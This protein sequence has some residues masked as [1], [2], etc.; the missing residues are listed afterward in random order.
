MV[1]LNVNHVFF[2]FFFLFSRFRVFRKALDA[3]IRD[4]TRAGVTL[5][6]KKEEKVPVTEN[7]EQK[8][9]ELGLLGCKSSKSLLHTVLFIVITE[10]Y[11]GFAAVN[12]EFNCGKF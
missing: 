7:E 12:I 1:V 3:E 8:F 5:K 10:S 9:L 11:L 2:F 4:G 6:N